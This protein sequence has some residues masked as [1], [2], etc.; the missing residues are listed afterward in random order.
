MLGWFMYLEDNRE[1]FPSQHWNLSA[2]Q[3]YSGTVATTE[4]GTY[5][6]LIYPY[7]KSF[8]VFM[9]PTSTRTSK[10]EQFDHDYAMS[11]WFHGKSMSAAFGSSS[12]FSPSSVG[13]IVDSYE[14]W[15]DSNRAGRVFARHTKR[16]NIGFVDGHVDSR[17]SADLNGTPITFGH[18]VTI[19]YWQTN[20]SVKTD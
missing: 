7:V 8:E 2:S 4:W 1:T 12:T 16:A 9:C 13:L 18:N 10:S 19:A 11:S 15:I 3:F 20:G 14:R 6:P 17:T 5:T